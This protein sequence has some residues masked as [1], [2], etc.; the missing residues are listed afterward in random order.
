MII[1]INTIICLI[2]IF[3]YLLIP[4]S[5]EITLY[6]NGIQFQGSSKKF[7]F[8]HPAFFY[9]LNEVKSAEVT[10][11]GET[12]IQF[13]F[14][15]PFVFPRPHSEAILKAYRKYNESTS[16]DRNDD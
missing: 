10:K 5:R 15:S 14:G 11:E 12:K 7:N 2:V 8:L 4:R 1:I 3:A 9:L 6:E 16:A 13:E